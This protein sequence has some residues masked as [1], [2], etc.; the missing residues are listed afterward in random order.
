MRV[1]VNV[2]VVFLSDPGGDDMVHEFVMFVKTLFW[3]QYP[4]ACTVSI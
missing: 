2:D 4:R 3:G 1:F